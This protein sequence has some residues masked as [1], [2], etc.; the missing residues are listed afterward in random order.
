MSW[1][2]PAFASSASAEVLFPF[3]IANRPVRASSAPPL[4]RAL[5]G[6]HRLAQFREEHPNSDSNE[7]PLARNQRCP[8]GTAANL[9]LSS[10]RWPIATST[11]LSTIAGSVTSL[12]SCSEPS[13]PRRADA[14]LSLGQ[15]QQLWSSELRKGRLMRSQSD[16]LEPSLAEMLVQSLVRPDSRP[17]TAPD[18]SGNLRLP[19]S[20]WMRP[21]SAATATSGDFY[22]TLR[23]EDGAPNRVVPGGNFIPSPT[24]TPEYSGRASQDAFM[25]PSPCSPSELRLTSLDGTPFAP[26]KGNRN[27]SKESRKA[28]SIISEDFRDAAAECD[29]WPGQVLKML[30]SDTQ[31]FAKVRSK[32]ALQKLSTADIAKA[33]GLSGDY[34]TAQGPRTA[35]ET[36]R[37]PMMQ[38][39]AV[40]QSQQTASA[41]RPVVPGLNLANVQMGEDDGELDTADEEDFKNKVGHEEMGRGVAG[42]LPQPDSE[43][44]RLHHEAL[45][46][47]KLDLLK[48][49]NE[50]GSSRNPS[51][52][53]MQK[54]ASAAELRSVPSLDQQQMSM[55]TLPPARPAAAPAAKKNDLSVYICPAYDMAAFRRKGA[56]RPKMKR[57]ESASALRLPPMMSIEKQMQLHKLQK[58]PPEQP[59]A[60]LQFQPRRSVVVH[61]HFHNHYHVHGGAQP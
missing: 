19:G 39:P 26:N 59:Q 23:A 25:S 3:A 12:L 45:G 60:Q 13:T 28:S 33:F 55:S 18:A 32:Q 27:G 44:R 34:E 42:H 43:Q 49:M 54:A 50:A 37:E 58:F 57:V 40:E 35:W 10:G 52:T 51:A 5:L 2:E 4:A 29:T 36:D 7:L 11:R 9:W 30:F 21:G 17:G 46:M 41:K 8:L 15:R 53:R 6:S 16:E 14:D 38:S 1:A 61:S 48:A 24:A 56:G 31:R 22:Q 20:N 47:P